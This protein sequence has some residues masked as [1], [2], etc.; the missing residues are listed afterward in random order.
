MLMV[1]MS[2]DYREYSPKIIWTFTRRQ[3]VCVFLAAPI[4]SFTSALTAAGIPLEYALLILSVPALPI[5]MCGWISV[6]GMP[7]ERF[8]LFIIRNWLMV[9]HNRY[10]STE[11]V[12]DYL[13]PDEENED[14]KKKG[15]KNA[16]RMTGKKKKKYRNDL[17]RY[18][19]VR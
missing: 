6:M 7:L 16:D 11:G 2:K 14:G 5:L 17:L 15:G 3:L 1:N 19:A 8:V 10:Y 9:P 12:F 13:S 18:G 4:Y